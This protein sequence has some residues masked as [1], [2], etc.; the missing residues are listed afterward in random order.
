VARA[1]QPP[2]KGPSSGTAPVRAAAQAHR[3]AP[4]DLDRLVHEQIRLGILS[5]LAVNTSLS[6]S[7][8][9]KILKTTD[10]N[11]SVHARRL[12]DAAYVKCRKFFNG[13]LPQTEFELTPTGR[14]AL[15]RY[16]D[17]MEALIQATRLH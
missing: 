10:G 7:D 11:L 14:Q 17:Q 8:L 6:F 4:T 15:E 5:A 3:A 12:E 9:K 2:I 1:T 13:R 16:L